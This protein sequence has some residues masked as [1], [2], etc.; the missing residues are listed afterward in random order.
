[1][2]RFELPR[3]ASLAPQA[4]VSTIPPHGRGLLND[5]TDDLNGYWL[6]PQGSRIVVHYY[7]PLFAYYLYGAPGEIRTPDPWFRRPELFR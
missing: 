4:S 3:L 6:S 1:M 2:G 5:L 7:E